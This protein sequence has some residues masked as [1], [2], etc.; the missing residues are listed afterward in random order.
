[1][2]LYSI[3]FCRNEL[4]QN[5]RQI[6][7]LLFQRLSLSKTTKYVRGIIVFL[8]FYAAKIDPSSLIEIID[9]IQAQ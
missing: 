4:Q 7:N 5:I 8:S 1:M 2:P 9:N 3:I 6:L